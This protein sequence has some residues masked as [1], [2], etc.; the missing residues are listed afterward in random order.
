MGSVKIEARWFGAS[1]A[2][3]PRI[4]KVGTEPGGC[5]SSNRKADPFKTEL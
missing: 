3:A 1:G 2:I 5:G 4:G